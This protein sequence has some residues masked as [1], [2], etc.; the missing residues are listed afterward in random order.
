MALQLGEPD[1]AD[2]ELLALVTHKNASAALCLGALLVVIQSPS[3]SAL[4]PAAG[5]LLERFA[6]DATVP[7]HMVQELLG[8]TEVS[9]SL[10]NYSL[11]SLHALILSFQ[12]PDATVHMPPGNQEQ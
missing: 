3:C 1:Q 6:E 7:L 4:K 10:W 9:S 5:I 12:G 8:A 2:A 11:V